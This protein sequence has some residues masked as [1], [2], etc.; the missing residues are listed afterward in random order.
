M[1]AVLEPT[2]D[3]QFGEKPPDGPPPFETAPPTDKPD[4]ATENDGGISNRNEEAIKVESDDLDAI[5]PSADP[6]EQ[7]I[8]RVP[9]SDN[10]EGEVVVVYVQKPLSY[11]RKMEFFKL[12]ARAMREAMEEGG[13]EF[14]TDAF[15]GGRAPRN[16]DT[17]RTTDFDDAGQFVS[18]VA[19]IVEIVPDVL[20]DCYVVWLGIP[21][22]AQ[23]EW[24]KSAMRGDIDGVQPLSDEDGVDIMKTFIVQNWEAMQA[25]FTDHA[26]EV[27]KVAQEQQRRS[28]PSDQ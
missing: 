19:A 9:D 15:S 22:G 20:E 4:E 12:L 5:L 21:R 13:G 14:L 2:Q 23:R 10:P 18:F 26:V 27:W 7:A 24:A 17:L 11:F 8:R 25:F 3:H 16:F 1:S 28:N 6:R